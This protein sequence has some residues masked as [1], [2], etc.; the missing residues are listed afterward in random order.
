MKASKT[1]GH[2]FSFCDHRSERD[3]CLAKTANHIQ[4][5]PVLALARDGY[6][7][8]PSLFKPKTIRNIRCSQRSPILIYRIEYDGPLGAPNITPIYPNICLV[9]KQRVPIEENLSGRDARFGSI[10]YICIVHKNI[11][12]QS[13]ISNR[14][15]GIK[16]YRYLFWLGFSKKIYF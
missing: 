3:N 12:I 16:Q 15:V 2:E 10:K 14:D 5:K 6:Y 11:G 1:L 8:Y 7:E 9:P 4:D 13:T